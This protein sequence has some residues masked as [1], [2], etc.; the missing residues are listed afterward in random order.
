MKLWKVTGLFVFS[1]MLTSLSFAG[2]LNGREPIDP[3]QYKAPKIPAPSGGKPA[4]REP[5]KDKPFDKHGKKGRGTTDGC[6]FDSDHRSRHEDAD[7]C[8]GASA[9]AAAAAAAAAP[10]V[11][12]TKK[13]CEKDKA[14]RGA[15]AEKK[16]SGQARRERQRDIAEQMAIELEYYAAEAE[17][18]CETEDECEELFDLGDYDVESED[19]E[20]VMFP[21]NFWEQNFDVN[22]FFNGA[23]ESFV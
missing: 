1:L 5:K 14:M 10:A 16:S 20:Q 17:Y 19:D 9:A 22:S 4:Q 7:E 18:E 2:L 21:P 11:R 6:A 12:T 8:D 3:S 15:R 23:A 13:T